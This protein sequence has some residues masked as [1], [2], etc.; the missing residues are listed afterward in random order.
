[1]KEFTS[2]N[3]VN[4]IVK[5]NKNNIILET[6]DKNI[7]KNYFLRF[8]FDTDSI[9]DFKEYLES[10]ANQMWCDFTPKEANSC[11]SDYED[12]YDRKYDN[13]GYLKLH[14]NGELSLEKP[15]K[16]C[17]YL[18]KFNKRRMESFI[19]DLSKC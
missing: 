8:K 1:M 16:D 4:L 17:P 9:K 13:N 11:S 15:D 2:K 5:H 18:Y 12:Y 7:V 3:G 10:I 19:Y 14:K 6:D